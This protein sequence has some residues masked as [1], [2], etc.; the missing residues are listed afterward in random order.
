MLDPD[1]VVSV[2]LLFKSPRSVVT[3]P[4]AEFVR[5]AP[6]SIR[7][8]QPASKVLLF[9]VVVPVLTTN[10]GIKLEAA[11]MVAELVPCILSVP[12]KTV[13]ELFAKK[14]VPFSVN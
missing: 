9:A 4:P 2:P 12:L 11:F 10:V 1:P 7:I 3:N 8:E 5:V 13:E 6:A 14:I